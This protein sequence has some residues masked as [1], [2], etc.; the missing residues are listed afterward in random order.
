MINTVLKLETAVVPKTLCICHWEAVPKMEKFTIWCQ[1]DS[2][3]HRFTTCLCEVWWKSVKGKWPKQ[4]FTGQKKLQT[5][6]DA[7]RQIHWSYFMKNSLGL[8]FPNPPSICQVSSKWIQFPVTYTHKHL[9]ASLCTL[10][11]TLLLV[12]ESDSWEQKRGTFF[13]VTC[14]WWQNSFNL[15]VWSFEI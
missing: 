14:H 15:G 13:C 4:W 11:Q 1:Y 6:S 12:S 9:P 5:L 7:T 2:C 3:G 8:I 10:Q